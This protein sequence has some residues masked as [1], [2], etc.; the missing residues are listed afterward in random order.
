MGR[1]GGGVVTQSK[2][3]T[4]KKCPRPLTCRSQFVRHLGK[5]IA[6]SDRSQGAA[7]NDYR[8]GQVSKGANNTLSIGWCNANFLLVFFAM[9][10]AA[11]WTLVSF[12]FDRR[13]C[14]VPKKSNL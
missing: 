4:A 9:L 14:F 13:K 12:L 5:Q 2:L 7:N 8:L 11:N 1:G 3:S 10:L 6:P